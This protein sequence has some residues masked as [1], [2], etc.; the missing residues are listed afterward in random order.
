LFVTPGQGDVQALPVED[1]PALRAG[2][3]RDVEH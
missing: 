2:H 1:V 3:P